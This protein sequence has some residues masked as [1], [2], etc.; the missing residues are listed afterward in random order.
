MPNV[1]GIRALMTC[2]RDDGMRSPKHRVPSSDVGLILPTIAHS[3]PYSDV[4]NARRRVRLFGDSIR[5]VASVDWFW[6]DGTRWQRDRNGELMRSART[7]PRPSS[8]ARS[9]SHPTPGRTPSNL[10]Y[11]PNKRPALPPRS[12]SRSR[13]RRLP[14]LLGV[15]SQPLAGGRRARRHRS[16]NRR[17]SAATGQRLPLTTA[18]NGVQSS[19]ACPPGAPFLTASRT[20]I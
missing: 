8:T 18:W 10:H 14:A 19:L 1:R 16:S 3:E 11:V 5:W 2:E 4:G 6:F 12:N 9:T 17:V 15:R 7:S 13:K 20:A